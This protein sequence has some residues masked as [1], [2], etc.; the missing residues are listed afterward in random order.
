MYSWL[1][2]P[3]TDGCVSHVPLVVLD[4]II[5]QAILLPPNSELLAPSLLALCVWCTVALCVFDI[6]PDSHA[7]PVTEV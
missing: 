1:R 4:L 7:L 5:F 6:T 2:V 3:H